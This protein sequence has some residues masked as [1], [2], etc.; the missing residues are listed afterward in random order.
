MKMKMMNVYK[1]GEVKTSWSAMQEE[2]VMKSFTNLA[3]ANQ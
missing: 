1:M 3:L 2:A